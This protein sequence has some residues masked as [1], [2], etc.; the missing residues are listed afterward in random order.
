MQIRL[1]VVSS[2]AQQKTQTYIIS[3]QSQ[4]YPRKKKKKRNSHL[5][6]QQ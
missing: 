1:S 4:L 3:F 6:K 2:E 5:R